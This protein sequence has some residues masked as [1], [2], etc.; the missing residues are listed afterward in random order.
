VV[1]D[2]PEVA[3]DLILDS[4]TELNDETEFV[5]QF[6]ASFDKKELIRNLAGSGSQTI[7]IVAHFSFTIMGSPSFST[8]MNPLPL[9]AQYILAPTKLSFS[10]C[11]QLP[12]PYLF[13]HKHTSYH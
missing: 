3:V 5:M 7:F 9:L 1:T 4:D 6:V 12:I 10:S 13:E 8:F 2:V 11:P